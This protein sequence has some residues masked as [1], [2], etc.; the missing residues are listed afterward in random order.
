MLDTSVEDVQL[1]NYNKL[2]RK[3]RSSEENRGGGIAYARSDV[4]V[5][6][7]VYDSPCA[8]CSWHLIHLD[9][10]SVAVCN[11]YRPLASSHLHI[12]IQN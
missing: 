4:Q 1:I 2:S 7:H 10:G 11:W 6:V 8:E 9:T 12:D 3:D 5:A